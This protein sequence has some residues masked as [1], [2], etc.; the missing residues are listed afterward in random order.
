MSIKLPCSGSDSEESFAAS[1]TSS[2]NEGDKFEAMYDEENKVYHYRF[3]IKVNKE[4]HFLNPKT[5]SFRN[6]WFSVCLK[7]INT[8][9][10]LC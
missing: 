6:L 5:C 1:E 4:F 10:N 8:I 7:K 3:K 9:C 2:F